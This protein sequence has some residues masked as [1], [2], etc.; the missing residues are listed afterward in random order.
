MPLIF[1]YTR[2]VVLL[3]SI[4]DS[5]I[6]IIQCNEYNVVF[7]NEIIKMHIINKVIIL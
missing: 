1:A 3:Y 2:K 7:D 5:L 6:Q 4:K